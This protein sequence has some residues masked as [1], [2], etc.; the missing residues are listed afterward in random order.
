MIL[1]RAHQ[2]ERLTRGLKEVAVTG[3]RVALVHGEAG[4]GKSTLVDAFIS[5]QPPTLGRMRGYC[6]PYRTPR[7][8]GPVRDLAAAVLG[9]ETGPPSES[10]YF[11]VLI[12]RAA[13]SSSP[14]VWVIED[15]HWAD[16]KSLDWLQF[17]ARRLSQLPVFLI[18]TFRDDEAD[19]TQALHN[20]LGALPQHRLMRLQLQP[21]S[22]DAVRDLCEGCDLAA[23]RMH[24]VTGGNPFFVTEMMNAGTG[25]AVPGAVADV[26][27]ARLSRLPGPLREFLELAACCPDEV[28][29]PV[30]EKILKRDVSHLCDRALEHRLLVQSRRGFRFRHEI[31][32]LAIYDRIPPGQRRR[33][34]AR[35]VLALHAAG[36]RDAPLDLMLHH[37]AA[38]GDIPLLL[39]LAPIA[40]RQAADFGAHREAAQHWRSALDH[41]D[42]LS[43][44]EAAE[45]NEN[46]AYEAALA[47]EIDEKVIAAR[48]AAIALW[49]QIGRG[50]KVGENLSWLSRMH[51]YRGEGDKAQELIHLA[52]VTLEAEAPDALAARARA[53]ALRA[54][55][56]MLQDRMEEAEDWGSRALELARQVDDA[57]ICCHALN[58]IGSARL[59]RGNAEGEAPLRESLQIAR[60]HGFHEQAAR[61]YTNLSECLIEMGA[62]D[63]AEVLI[64]EGIAFDS[65]HDLNSWTYYLVGRKAQLRFEQDRYDEA[66][67]IAESALAQP[68][69]TALMRMPAQIILVR[70]KLRC[71]DADAFEALDAALDV[72]AGVAEPQYLASLQIAQFEAGFLYGAPDRL[73]AASAW[74]E[75]LDP[76]L[77]SPRKQGEYLF[78]ARLAGRGRGS[79]PSPELPAAFAMFA[80]GRFDQ[81]H[82]AFLRAGSRYLAAWSL[83][84]RGG[85]G[86]RSAAIDLMEEIGATAAIDLLRQ[87]QPRQGAARG[88]NRSRVSRRHLYGL[89][90]QEQRILGMVADGLANASIAERLS[91]SPRTIENHVSSILSKLHCKNRIGAVLRLQ[92]EPW[93]LPERPEIPEK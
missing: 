62:L 83:V 80:A 57:E 47:M 50:D 25:Q 79:D 11:N 71:G 53:S 12:Q 65:G 66:R 7:P 54:Q 81:A 84:A 44:A 63:R 31:A 45:I 2:I 10:R 8:L 42:A 17:F 21:L 75:A 40:A 88:R 24:Q 35:F 39:Q 55:F 67:L 86:D 51:W 19:A 46:W 13:Q 52:I 15:L 22:A 38:A 89:T 77:L 59:F 32:R 93:I 23:D 76:G 69:Q 60:S 37:A 64:E 30:L 36:R 58:T 5:A 6:D 90:R 68:R 26:I 85:Q 48:E 34:H 33:A 3:G 82:A 1:E 41:A 70:T 16:Q 73:A 61:V 4:I 91:R 56:H 74:L 18:V 20:A 87:R 29:V 27:N 49:R 92:A 28:P 43:P 9:P 72:A 78:W 14:M